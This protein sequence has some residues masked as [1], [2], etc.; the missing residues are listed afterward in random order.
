MLAMLFL[1]APMNESLPTP[2]PRVFKDPFALEIG[3]ECLPAGS[4]N[5]S[6]R[7]LDLTD[8]SQAKFVIAG[9]GMQLS[10]GFLIL[11]LVLIGFSSWSIIRWGTYSLLLGILFGIGFSG[12]GLILNYS[13][14]TPIV[15]DKQSGLFWKGRGQPYQNAL[16][17][18]SPQ[19]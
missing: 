10:Y 15:F 14:L 16:G 11:G 3:W 4:S 19:T 7:R 6:T 1:A 8:P 18:P 13:M 2:D 12:L 9:E 17:G 5:V